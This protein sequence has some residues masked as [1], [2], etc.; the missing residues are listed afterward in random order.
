MP[1]PV[2]LTDIRHS[3]RSARDTLLAAVR[4]LMG[5]DHYDGRVL[6]L[7]DWVTTGR[8]ATTTTRGSREADLPTRE[9]VAAALGTSAEDAGVVSLINAGR[10]V[11]IFAL[12]ALSRLNEQS[13]STTLVMIVSPDLTAAVRGRVVL[14]A[15]GYTLTQYEW[16]EG[17]AGSA[18]VRSLDD[19]HPLHAVLNQSPILAWRCGP[20]AT[21]GEEEKGR[22][23]HERMMTRR[24]DDEEASDG[25]DE[26]AS[27]GDEGG[28]GATARQSDDDDDEGGGGVTTRQS[29]DKDRKVEKIQEGE[30]EVTTRQSEEVKDEDPQMSMVVVDKRQCLMASARPTATVS[31]PKIWQTFAAWEVATS[32]VL[33]DDQSIASAISSAS[34]TISDLSQYGFKPTDLRSTFRYQ[35]TT[36]NDDDTQPLNDDDKDEAWLLNGP[37]V[38]LFDRTRDE[39]VY[40]DFAAKEQRVLAR[41]ACREVFVGDVVNVVRLKPDCQPTGV[42]SFIVETSQ[43]I[44]EVK[45]GIT[46]PCWAEDLK[47]QTSV[48]DVVW[49]FLETGVEPREVV[50]KPCEPASIAEH[51]ALVAQGGP[52]RAILFQEPKLTILV[53][54]TASS[55]KVVGTPSTSIKPWFTV[56]SDVVVRVCG[57]LLGTCRGQAAAFDLLTNLGFA[58]DEVY[59]GV[60]FG[61]C[62]RGAKR[63]GVWEG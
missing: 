12:C 4:R 25:D 37:C 42:P 60:A 52:V 34:T 29:E 22:E 51:L 47:D 38:L 20:H 54:K 45:A 5:E 63:R 61:K 27:D 33:A 23:D 17:S 1:L 31:V 19:G 57:P 44:G 26:E 53:A 11:R 18:M 8:R 56:C 58:G 9:E 35:Q 10:P 7:A 36:F 13:L 59:S 24:D 46:R 2:T 62:K 30:G 16:P 41:A 48:A 40:I 3:P 21:P 49:G 15:S 14:V 39:A 32:F 28:G 6:P 43:P 55:I 50:E